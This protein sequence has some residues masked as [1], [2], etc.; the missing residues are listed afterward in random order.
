[1]EFFEFATIVVLFAVL[2]SIIIN[3]IL[4]AKRMKRGGSSGKRDAL[5]MS[6][7]Q[8]LIEAAVEDA[9]APLQAR[10]D[11]LEE[12]R[13]LL[14]SPLRRKT[15]SDLKMLEPEPPTAA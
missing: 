4:R 6:D 5:R 14:D 7:L 9:T 8:L 1:M 11:M 15:L 13:L 10:L 2:P 12:E 3:G